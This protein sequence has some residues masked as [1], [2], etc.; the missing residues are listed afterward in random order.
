MIPLLRA[1][2][3]LGNLGVAFGLPWLLGLPAGWTLLLGAGLFLLV[4]WE[5]GRAP[6][7][8]DAPEAHVAL[9]AQ[10][11][12]RLGVEPARFLRVVPGWTAAAVRRG[13]GYG[14]LVG[15]DVRPE[16][17]EA[18]LAHEI[19]HFA[20]GDLLWEPFTDGPARIVLERTR[21]LP[22]LGLI[23]L[24]F[25][26]WGAPLARL[27]ELRA[28]RLAADAVPGYAATLRELADKMGPGAGLLYPS[29]GTR[30]RHS[31]R[32]S[33]TQLPAS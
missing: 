25:L 27:T 4:W 5:T 12:R 8:R 13:R 1:A 3:L 21:A 16:H 18:V 28:D 24:P 31:A 10:A 23:A 14:L 11:A 22:P 30:V 29:L 2:S 20:A 26:L 19:A 6:A 17:V 33:K 9:A 15:E 7:G 32:H